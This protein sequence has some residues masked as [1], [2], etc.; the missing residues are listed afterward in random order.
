MSVLESPRMLVQGPWSTFGI[1]RG[2]GTPLE[3]RYWRGGGT[4]HFFL[5]TLFSKI[6]LVI[7]E[8]GAR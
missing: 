6:A 3:T 5:L 4:S 2:G 7:I 1:G 8:N